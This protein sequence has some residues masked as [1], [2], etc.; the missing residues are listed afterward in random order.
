LQRSLSA[1]AA[2]P[3]AAHGQTMSQLQFSMYVPSRRHATA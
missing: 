2:N 1:G 3:L